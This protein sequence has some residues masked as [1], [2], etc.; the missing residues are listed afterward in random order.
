M[1]QFE[2]EHRPEI[3]ERTFESPYVIWYEKFGQR[4]EAG[5]PGEPVNQQPF[6]IKDTS[7]VAATKS[8][9]PAAALDGIRITSVQPWDPDTDGSLIPPEPWHRA[10]L[11]P[12]SVPQN[13]DHLAA[14]PSPGLAKPQQDKQLVIVAV[15]DDATNFA[16]HRF[17]GAN[18]TSRVDY[19]W[20]M[21]GKPKDPAAPTVPFGREWSNAEIEHVL[22]SSDSEDAVL[23][24]LELADFAQNET[25]GL[26][27]RISHGTHVMD[28]ACGYEPEDEDGQDRRIISVQ[29]PR[30]VILEASGSILHLFVKAAIRYIEARAREI[31][32]A[33]GQGSV[34]LVVNFSYGLGAGSRLGSHPVEK[35]FAEITDAG[36]SNDS[37]N[38]V[39]VVLPAG[40]RFRAD[41][42]AA[43]I[44]DHN[45]QHQL[46]LDWMLPAQDQSPNFLEIWLPGTALDRTIELVPPNARFG[47][48][49]LIQ[50][51]G[52]YLELVDSDS[53]KGVA[54]A[55]ADVELDAQRNR[56]GKIRL[57]LAIAPT[58][59]PRL[60]PPF[61]PAG[62]WKIR[63]S[64]TLRTND[65]ICA[66][67][68]RD[69]PPY[70]YRR[71]G[72]PSRL[73]N[74]QESRAQKIDNEISEYVN[75]FAKSGRVTGYG[76]LNGIATAESMIVVAGYRWRDASC[77]SYSS[78]GSDSVRSPDMAAISDRS[79]VLG[80]VLAA[81]S[82]SAVKV[83]LNGTSVA[84]PQVVN[85]LTQALVNSLAFGGSDTVSSL[86]LGAL[87]INTESDH[88]QNKINWLRGR[89]TRLT[90]E[91][92]GV[93]EQMERSGFRA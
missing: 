8:G 64:A 2:W 62:V 13:Y 3:S 39:H 32:R 24:E 69:E 90:A 67:I 57:L 47:A 46:E 23:K 36:D 44:A 15:V 79:R 35:C 45:G 18:K 20:V 83:A 53:K 51:K 85:A 92:G 17:Q 71:P 49:A 42:H 16:H 66:W 56:V 80:G 75:W 78:A 1:T 38:P 12:E 26:T 50:E 7:N 10:P 52:G 54:W 30:R 5:Y 11:R 93:A 84:V 59:V 41:G 34:P 60:E 21:D 91:G 86:N 9:D 25:I 31:A 72:Q 74:H 61:A 43:L 73:L 27:K 87:V 48:A 63:V 65:D 4:F 70:G 58:Y 89:D 28:L 33:L 55:A 29:L 81:G 82:R 37:V 40:N 6:W 22:K 77:A 19:A 88:N 68:Q 76:T 14:A